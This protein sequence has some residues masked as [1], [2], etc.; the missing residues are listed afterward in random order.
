MKIGFV[1]LPLSGHVLPMSSLMRRLH[2]RGH[3]VVFVGVSDMEPFFSEADLPF[4]PYCTESFPRGSMPG[5][6]EPLAKMHG[7]EILDY[8]GETICPRLLEAALKELPPLLLQHG[9]DALVVDTDFFYVQLAA[10]SVH[11]PFVQVFLALHLDPTGS[12]PPLVFSW[13]YATTPEALA[14]N[15]RGLQQLEGL[16]APSGQIGRAFTER[17]SFPLDWADPNAA[18][19]K[20][21]LITQTPKAF[22]YPAVGLPPQWHYTGPFQD[23]QGRRAIPFPWQDLDGRPLVYVSLGTLVNG[24]DRVYRIILEAVA[25]MPDLQIVL[26]TGKNITAKDLGDIPPNTIVVEQ[27]PQLELLQRAALCITHAGLNTV[28]EALAQGVPMVAI[29]IGFDQPGVAARMA[30]HHTGEFMEVEEVTAAGLSALIRK[31]Y[32][33]PEYREKAQRFQQIIAHTRGLDT[34]AEVVETAFAKVVDEGG[35]SGMIHAR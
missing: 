22:D 27:A 33:Q 19:S 17:V 10:M 2:S 18:V 20:L 9:I 28:M 34:A 16:H 29:P 7:Q 3:A 15:Q 14:R 21:A 32:E 4:L 12:T 13:P 30:Y 8:F 23:G 11:I 25:G 5:L 24:L 35:A 31:V 6:W 26:S 1:C